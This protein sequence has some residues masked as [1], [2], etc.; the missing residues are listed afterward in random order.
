VAG[1]RRA[2]RYQDE[3]RAAKTPS[4]MPVPAEYARN[5]GTEITIDVAIPV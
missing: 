4:S 2:A 1:R 3:K 5:P